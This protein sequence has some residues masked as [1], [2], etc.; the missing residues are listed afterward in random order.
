MIKVLKNKNFKLHDSGLWVS[1]DGE[2]Y[3]PK[4]GKRPAHFTYG[5][6]GN[7][8]YLLVKYKY[9]LYLVHRL[10]A[11]CWIPNPDNLKTVDH[12]NQIRTD[13]RV[14]NLRWADMKLQTQNRG[15]YKKPNTPKNNAKS[16]KVYQYTLDG[17]LVKVWPSTAECGRNGFKQS[18]VAACCNNRF[19]REGN[20]VYKGFIWS[21]K[22]PSEIVKI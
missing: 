14:K 9:Q 20:N 1:K 10:V 19:N 22:S 4:S 21:Y 15:K 8:G 2:V 17:Q 7:R 5:S 18:C 12:E 3:V 13:N 11:Q 6:L 16:K